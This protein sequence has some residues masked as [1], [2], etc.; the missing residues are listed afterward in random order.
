V[1]GLWLAK[2]CETHAA[3][4]FPHGADLR[5][6]GRHPGPALKRL[7]VLLEALDAPAEIIVV[8]DR[9]RDSSAI[10]IEANARADKRYW[11][12]RSRSCRGEVPAALY[13]RERNRLRG[14]SH[15]GSTGGGNAELS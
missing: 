12:I 6:G 3:D 5:R 11:L 4:L 15:G 9:S 8:D 10:V 7:D 1:S 13:C 14:R 2:G